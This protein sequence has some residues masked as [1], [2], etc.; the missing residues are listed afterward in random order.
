MPD[1]TSKQYDSWLQDDGPAA[2][3]LREYLQSVEGQDD[4]VFPATYAPTQDKSFE[5]GYNI[6][7]FDGNRN[8]C[9]MDSVGSQ[10]NRL[11]PLFKQATYRELVPQV[12][13][14]IGAHRVNLLDAGHRAADAIVRYSNLRAPLEKAFIAL[15]DH[16]NAEELAKIAPTSIVFGMWDSR[17]TQLKLP[18]LLSSVIRAYDVEKMTRSANFLPPLVTSQI[19]EALRLDP[20]SDEK[21]DELSELGLL[22]SLASKGHGGVVSRGGIRRDAILSLAGLRLLAVKEREGS[23]ELSVHKT[24][25]LR[26]YILGLALVA[27]TA[28]PGEQLRQGCILVADPARPRTVEAVSGDGTR[29]AVDLTHERAIAY[30]RAAASAFG[31]GQNQEVEFDT[32]A[33]NA[34]LAKTKKERRKGRAESQPSAGE[35]S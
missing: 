3:V 34:D 31:V 23:V 13:I 19:R 1:D 21:K 33:V 27:L 10:A 28:R 14:K 22:N 32:K 4:T 5:G 7:S 20:S 26:R 6:D 12:V 18:R 2:L 15:R 11:E 16:G 17:Q 8:V 24:M 29:G 30:A 25:G 9:L 35:A